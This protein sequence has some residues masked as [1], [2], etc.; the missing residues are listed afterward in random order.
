MNIAT[1]SKLKGSVQQC[2]K[3]ENDLLRK[4][5][6]NVFDLVIYIRLGKWLIDEIIM[7]TFISEHNLSQ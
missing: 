4:R 6:L 3:S 1:W 2:V 5:A 7:I